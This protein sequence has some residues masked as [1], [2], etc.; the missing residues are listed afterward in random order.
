MTDRSL[1]FS[2]TLIPRDPVWERSHA[3]TKTTM[4]R[5][6]EFPND[7]RARFRDAGERMQM[8]QMRPRVRRGNGHAEEVWPS[9]VPR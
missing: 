1:D 9:G 5:G 4:L 2:I 3:V 7:N 8:Q 6:V